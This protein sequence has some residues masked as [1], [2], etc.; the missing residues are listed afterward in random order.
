MTGRPRLVV[1]GRVFQ[2]QARDRGMG[3]YSA[4]LLRAF[5]ARAP[6]TDIEVVVA[7]SVPARPP[8]I[9][10]TRTTAL[11]LV[12]PAGDD[13]AA[14]RVNAGVLEAHLRS[15]SSSAPQVGLLLLS[16]L[17][18][19]LSTAVP[20]LEDVPVSALVYDLIPLHHEAVYLRRPGAR[21]NYLR[22]LG[23]LL[24]VDRVLTISRTVSNDVTRDLG[25]D[26]RR[27]TCIGGAAIDQ[28]GDDPTRTPVPAGP[29][30][31]MP[32]GNDPR[33]NN[34]RAVEAF[35]RFNA[36]QGHRFR[37]LVTSSFRT[38]ERASL[39]A[40]CGEVEF[41]G[42]VPEGA[43]AS[44]YENAAAV[45]FP[46]EDEGLGLPLLE[47]LETLT[48]VACSDIPAFHEVS[49][50]LFHLFDP[51]S[52]LQMSQALAAAVD[53][54]RVDA[55]QAAEVLDRYR[56]P[57]V[58]ARLERALGDDVSTA[59]RPGLCIQAPAASG[60]GTV[61]VIHAELARRRPV[62]YVLAEGRSAVIRPSWLPYLP[63]ATIIGV[64]TVLGRRCTTIAIHHVDGQPGSGLTLLA[65]LGQP[66]L[67][68]LH[69][70]MLDGAWTELVDLGLLSPGRVDLDL[71]LEASAG[72]SGTS[73]LPALLADRHRVVVFDQ[74]AAARVRAVAERAGVT[75]HVVLLPRPVA[76]VAEPHLVARQRIML[77]AQELRGLRGRARDAAISAAWFAELPDD[78][79][80]LEVLLVLR[81]GTVPATGRPGPVA[82][83]PGAP[84]V[85]VADVAD[86]GAGERQA[87]SRR[88]VEYV[89]DHHA[90]GAVAAT[91]A[92]LAAAEIQAQSISPR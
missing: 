47:A 22:R 77:P 58:A 84:A 85:A 50:T 53:G 2:T 44:L 30:V 26:P 37:L 24:S 18:G 73:H 62:S 25:I 23:T 89:R 12:P 70:T 79:T 74:P 27:V 38:H 14:E 41:L 80:T 81:E 13:A 91:I 11:P 29:Y 3:R 88:A 83:L 36:T 42:S 63:D 52:V 31:L 5:A 69:D 60:H 87:L 45:L 66:G 68:V 75:T 56:W 46:S 61:G 43:L 20:K 59:P 40:A 32:T 6:G 8:S 78:A 39:R 9:P 55:A 54:G 16:C 64:H 1:D 65:A 19:D 15:A 51:R 67:L 28:R 35:A 33:K 10:G 7:A 4:A 76:L 82:M 34:R 72:V 86:L 90:P 57:D 17:Q 49:D 21:A 92:E 71:A 48:P